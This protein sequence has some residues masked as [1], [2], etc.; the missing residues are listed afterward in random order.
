MTKQSKTVIF[1]GSGPLA[2]NSLQLLTIDFEIEAV[3]TKST[4]SGHKGEVPVLE[5]TKKLNIKTYCVDSRAQLD[6]LIE[7][8]DFSSQVGILIDF[9]IIVSQ[10]V[11]DYFK[12]GIINSHFSILPQWRGADPISFALLSGQKT[13]G[14]SLMLLVEAMDEGP[15]LGYS[16]IDIDPGDTNPA[17]SDKLVDLSHSLIKKFVPS[18]LEGSITAQPQSITGKSISYSRKLTKKDGLIDWTKPANKIEQE[19][20]TFIEW[21]KSYTKIGGIEVIITAARVSSTLNLKSG[22]FKIENDQLFIG[23]GEA[24]LSIDKLKPSGKSEMPIKAFLAGYSSR[25]T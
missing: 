19:I 10:K 15:L 23:C 7:S 18:Y 9:G 1:F 5:L 13:T 22:E 8:S 25:L 16:E 12:K 6:E 14:V 20:R 4:P 11:I 3:I 17:L 21:P 24:S 2:A